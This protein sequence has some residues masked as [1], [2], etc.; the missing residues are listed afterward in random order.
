MFGE[1]TKL[2][3][4]YM[5]LQLGVSSKFPDLNNLFAAPSDGKL[6][7][8]AQGELNT[9]NLGALETALNFE[10]KQVSKGQEVGANGNLVYK[11]KMLFVKLLNAPKLGIFDLAS[12]KNSWYKVDL[13]TMIAADDSLIKKEVDP[14]KEKAL[15]KLVAKTNFLQIVEDKGRVDLDGRQVYDYVVKPNKKEIL[16]FFK[17]STKIMDGRNLTELEISDLEKTLADIEK[18]KIEI[19]VGASDSL[20]YK[21]VISTE[22]ATD[23]EKSVYDIVLKLDKMNQKVEIKEP[24]DAKDF[25]FA[26]MLFGGLN[27]NLND[28][29][30]DF[31]LEINLDELNNG[32]ILQ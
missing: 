8:S 15:R 9:Q 5:D 32:N 25:D 30:K 10:I 21:T 31:K 26:S 29:S 3:S 6:I 17:G 23:N 24:A 20:L 1:M 13:N 4:A 7:V 19:W 12:L 16:D 11:G 27:A 14:K 28:L 22:L 18:A 2:E